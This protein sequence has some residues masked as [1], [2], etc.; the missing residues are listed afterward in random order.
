MLDKIKNEWHIV[1]FHWR[2]DQKKKSKGREEK[3]FYLNI[4]RRLPQELN[5]HQG[6]LRK[7]IEEIERKQASQFSGPTGSGSPAS[8]TSILTFYAKTE[9]RIKLNRSLVILGLLSCRHSISRSSVLNKW[10]EKILH[11]LF[12]FVKAEY[13]GQVDVL[14]GQ[15]S[16]VGKLIKRIKLP[17]LEV[18]PYRVYSDGWRPFSAFWWP[19]S[20][21]C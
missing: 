3:W 9:F 17:W 1:H 20:C 5:A 13:G 8:H 12:F 10:A 16:H 19:F 14:R 15:S 2:L 6:N 7:T 4:F 18:D 11:H 21:R